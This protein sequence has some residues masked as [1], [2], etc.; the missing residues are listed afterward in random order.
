MSVVPF[1]LLA[2]VSLVYDSDAPRAKL[3]PSQ[4]SAVDAIKQLRGRVALDRQSGKVISVDLFNVK[5][6]DAGLLHLK[7]LTSLKK[8][9]IGSQI[10]AAGLKE[11]KTALPKCRIMREKPRQ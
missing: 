1:L 4:K 10:T 11:I 2:S 5:T 3:D 8:L 6:A 9:A 7:G